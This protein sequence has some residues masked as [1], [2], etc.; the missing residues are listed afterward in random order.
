M[1]ASASGGFRLACSA[2]TG[3]WQ[4]AP[5][6][7]EARVTALN[8]SWVLFLQRRFFWRFWSGIGGIGRIDKGQKKPLL[9]LTP[10]H[11]PFD[12][13]VEE[14]RMFIQISL[15]DGIDAPFLFRLDAFIF[16][17]RLRLGLSQVT[18]DFRK[19]LQ[20]ILLHDISL[21]SFVLGI[22]SQFISRWKICVKGIIK[23]ESGGLNLM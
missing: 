8:F 16:F 6:F 18:L 23:C 3:G 15:D 2:D 4:K 11:F 7:V 1:S 13:I 9:K 22:K 21:F 12:V 19:I 17:L 10:T 20:P 5:R 14:G